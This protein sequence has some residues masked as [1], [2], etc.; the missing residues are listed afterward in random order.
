MLKKALFTFLS[1]L[2]LSSSSLAAMGGDWIGFG[3][4]TFKGEGEGVR[5]NPMTLKMVETEKTFSMND[6]YFDCEFVG[7][8]VLPQTWTKK[9]N[10]LF[11]ESNEEVGTYDGKSLFVE[12]PKENETTRIQ[13]SMKREANHI[14]YQE[15]WFNEFEKVYVITAR[16][17][18]GQQ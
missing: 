14:D 16:F 13:V 4:W 8:R 17:F 3:R 7:M 9:D 5:C 10:K 12:L 6:G 1:V 2:I 15:V 18:T 11:N